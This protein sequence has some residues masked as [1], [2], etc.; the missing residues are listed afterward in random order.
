MKRTKDN[1]LAEKA[2]DAV[3]RLAA[4][5]EKYENEFELLENL[6]GW[7]FLEWSKQMMKSW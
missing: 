1:R 2:R 4:Y 6:D 3:Y 5:F 7:I